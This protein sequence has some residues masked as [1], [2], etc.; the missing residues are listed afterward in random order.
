MK[1]SCQSRTVKKITA[2]H[3]S[4]WEEHNVTTSDAGS[5]SRDEDEA[6]QTTSTGKSITEP[7][8]TAVRTSSTHQPITEKPTNQWQ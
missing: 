1:V 6:T 8:S 2:W 7:R 5:F 3:Q 4:D